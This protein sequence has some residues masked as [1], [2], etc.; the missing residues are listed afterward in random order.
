MNE[1]TNRSTD[2][3]LPV[4]FEKCV[5]MFGGDREAVINLLE[6]FLLLLKQQVKT[7]SEALA[8]INP[9]I[10]LK[11]AHSIKGGAAV[12]SSEA[13]AGAA[14][15]IESIGRSGDLSGGESALRKLKFEAERL[16]RYCSEL[17]EEELIHNRDC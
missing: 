3:P 8:E 13:L 17:R 4:D 6:E 2:K 7:I 16:A 15:E 11:E 14:Y 1:N 9:D 12:L 5:R 10:V